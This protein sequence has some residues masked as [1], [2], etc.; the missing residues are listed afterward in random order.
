MTLWTYLKS[1]MVKYGDRVAFGNSGI[2]YADLLYYEKS[3]F[4]GAKLVLCEGDRKELQALNIIQ[5]LA[6]GNVAVPIRKEDG[7]KNYDYIQ[8]KVDC[9]KNIEDL[10]FIMFTSGTTGRPKGVML[11]HE[12][13][14]SNLE[15]IQ[16]Y[17]NLEG[18]KRICISRS[19]VH[20]SALTGEF[21]YALC[22][23]L[24]I[25]FYEESFIPQ[26]LLLYFIQNRIDVFCATPTI[27]SSLATINRE[28]SDSIKIASISG[29]ILT[30]KTCERILRGFPK[31]KFYNAYGLTEHSPRISALLPLD[32]ESKMGSVG[33]PI[34]NVTVKIVD[35]DLLVQSSSVMKGYYLDE[36]ETKKKI[37]CEGWLRTGDLAHYDEEGYLYIDGRKDNMLIRAG[38]N[39]YPE[40]I[41]GIVKEI[42]EVSDCLVRG[43]VT[44]RGLEIC[45]EYVGNIEVKELRKKLAFLL[46]I[47]I[48]PNKIKRVDNL[49]KTLSGKKCRN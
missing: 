27:F 10:A 46:N 2:T 44:D 20:I 35:N 48:L 26:R 45:L 31:T 34:G 42:D 9:H 4:Q 49:E 41:E 7:L 39:V 22:N 21:L 25:Y 18:M 14:I 37:L 40:E 24:T 13:I 29:E 38:V 43:E 23:G 28:G 33:K 15:Y 47:N 19:L 11:T 5:C 36:E 16:S 12:N 6:S 3:N 1:K 30:R 17:F 8:D 32:F